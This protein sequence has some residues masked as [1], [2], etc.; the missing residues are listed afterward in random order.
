MRK[1]LTENRRAYVLVNNRAEGN[2]P[3]TVEGLVGML[4]E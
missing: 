4:R 1:A 2:A 3:L